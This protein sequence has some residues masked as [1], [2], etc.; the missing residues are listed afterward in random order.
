MRG[1]LRHAE[2]MRGRT[3]EFR[4]KGQGGFT[5]AE[6]VVATS[7]VIVL[8]AVA[9]V[10][11]RGASRG[12]LLG[13]GAHTIAVDLRRVQNMALSAALVPGP[14]GPTVPLGGYG[15]F[16]SGPAADRYILFADRDGGQDYD[17]SSVPPERIEERILEGRM[18]FTGFR[19]GGSTTNQPL[20][21]IFCPPYAH[22]LLYTM[23]VTRGTGPCSGDQGTLQQSLTLMLGDS[24]GTF[25]SGRT[26]RDVRV[27]ATGAIDI[28]SDQEL[29]L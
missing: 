20:V 5:L 25:P 1:A 9:L 8:S 16:F 24:S 23:N 3:G 11:Y 7:I 21:V 14:S 12:E 13:R 17:A 27:Y 15:I 26:V 19:A 4:D 10:N 29:G 22:T 6:F 2:K 28:A 18:R